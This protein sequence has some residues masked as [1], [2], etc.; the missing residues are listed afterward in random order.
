M[1]AIAAAHVYAN[2]RVLPVRADS[3]ATYYIGG[4][5]LSAVI[6]ISTHFADA[7]FLLDDRDV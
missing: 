4:R 7:R 2:E 5:E 1:E 3:S 6:R